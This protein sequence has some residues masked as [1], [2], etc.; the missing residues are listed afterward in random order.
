MNEM[1]NGEN[2]NQ[3][4][5]QQNNVVQPEQPVSE[6]PKKEEFSAPKKSPFGEKNV[7]TQMDDGFSKNKEPL[8]L[9]S[10]EIQDTHNRQLFLFSSFV[11]SQIVIHFLLQINSRILGSISQ[12]RDHIIIHAKGVN[13]IEVSITF[14]ASIAVILHPLPI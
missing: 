9:E 8:S 4:I 10:E 7:I 6:T 5:E 3:N 13:P 11:A 1:N 14:H 12:L 2:N